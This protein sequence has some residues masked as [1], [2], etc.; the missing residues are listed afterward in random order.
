M[1]DDATEL[2]LQDDPHRRVV[3]IGDTVRRPAQPWTP[4]V[5]A[6]LRHLE[7]VGFPY[8]P[9]V[10]GLD[11]EGR[12][13][14]SHIDGDAGPLGWA[15]IVPDDGLAAFA[16]LLRDYHDATAGFTPPDEVS[17]AV[18]TGGAGDGQV[19]CHGDFGPWNVVWRDHRPVGLIDWDFAHPAA[20][21]HDVAYAL[22]YAAPFRDDAEALRWLRYPEPPNRRRRVELFCAAYGLTSTDG[23]VDAV[24][25]AQRAT[26]AIAADLAARGH[27]PQATWAANGHL[28]E[29]QTRIDWTL[30][31][32]HLVE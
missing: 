20:P 32:R 13:I 22:E 14:L 29:L 4:A 31:H 3:R 30:S 27:E 17:W 16:L 8:A 19:I 1:A 9:R 24:A 10:L 18:G 6:L 25:D 12:E 15:P 26:R 2:T 7:S 11:A 5:H 23:I 28:D 21:L